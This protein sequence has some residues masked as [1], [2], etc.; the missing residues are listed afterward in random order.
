MGL[1]LGKDLMPILVV[2]LVTW[3]GV[4]AYMFRLDR[5]TLDLA[6]RL[7]DLER[8]GSRGIRGTEAPDEVA[9]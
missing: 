7:D 5:S 3:G 9:G 8:G 2:A 6:R 1:E 4:L